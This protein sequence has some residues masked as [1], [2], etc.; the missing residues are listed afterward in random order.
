LQIIAEASVRLRVLSSDL[1][2]S[3]RQEVSDALRTATDAQKSYGSETSNSTD[4]QGRFRKALFESSSIL[5]VFKKSLDA[6]STKGDGGLFDRLKAKSK[7]AAENGVRVFGKVFDEVFTGKTIQGGGLKALGAI[8][9]GV[10]SVLTSQIVRMGATFA[11]VLGAVGGLAAALPALG[12][13]GAAAMA[14]I[15]L[16]MDGIKKAAGALSPQLDQLKEKVSGVFAKEMKP[17]FQ[18]IG[19]ILP[20]IQA[21]LM[22]MASSISGV[23]KQIT[24]GLKAPE[25]LADLK[26]AL[27]GASS[28]VANLGEGL[29]DMFTSIIHSAAAVSPIMD[30]LGASIGGI[31]STI[32]GAF[33]RAANTGKLLA[34]AR[35]IRQVFDA[36]SDVLGP[37]LD[38]LFDFAAQLAG[39]LAGVLSSFGAALKGASPG[40]SQFAKGIS[41][42]LTAIA[43]VIKSLGPLF[44]QLAGVVGGALGQAMKALAP[45][46]KIIIDGL[47]TALAPVLPILAQAFEDLARALAPVLAQFAGVFVQVLQTL[48]PLIPVILDAIMQLAPA[49]LMLVQALLPLLPPLAQLIATVLPPLIQLFVTILRP[50]LEFAAVIIGKLVP[51]ITKILS[52][53]GSMVAGVLNFFNNLSTNVSAILNKIGAFFSSIW[54]SIK[55]AFLQRIHAMVDS[56]KSIWSAI[57]GFFSSLF[58]R[59]K[60]AVTTG[61]GKVKN[62]VVQ[63]FQT[64]VQF[65]RDLPGKVVS[66]LGNL[67]SL[68]LAAGR[69]ILQGLLNGLLEVWNHITSFV[70]GIGSWIA[71]H[72]GP[73][74]VDRRLLIPA[75]RAIMGGLQSGLQA[76][77]SNVQAYVASRTAALSATVAGALNGA[78]GLS[79][80]APGLMVGITPPGTDTAGSA[81]PDTTDSDL[82]KMTA[83]VVA[84]MEQVQVI[85][86]GREVTSTVNRINA[87]N[88]GR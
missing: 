68:L 3:I 71:D 86:S 32:A 14:A 20:T 79:G 62:G 9:T 23:F 83:A 1:K 5:G 24:A 11:P 84:G 82:D 65:F 81:A 57:V 66:A 40:L 28:F 51:A 35:G 56:A 44:G 39:P 6:A 63:G 46:L 74:S 33:N 17:A 36:I 78:S 60:S 67:G 77:W 18:D 48:A 72:K 70:S 30:D 85:V 25:A 43:P 49:F 47:T 55:G 22:Q 29:T 26:T 69:A 61:I 4:K 34:A 13:A 75:G 31:F 59:V 12:V 10:F 38:L 87:G 37:L 41:S 50:V 19:K 42:A 73:I 21:G 54:E 64:V 2:R 15:G 45:A 58:E 8:G 53:V 88:R 27:A 76:E 52:V 80:T 16:G 7:D